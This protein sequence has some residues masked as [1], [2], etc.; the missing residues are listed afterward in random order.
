MSEASGSSSS[1][2]DAAQKQA[3]RMKKLRQL[4]TKR[5]ISHVMT[6]F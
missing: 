5:V 2:Q 3:E 1:S 4:H 6:H